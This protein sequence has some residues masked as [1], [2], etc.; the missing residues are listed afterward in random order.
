MGRYAALVQR[1]GHRRWFAAVGRWTT[2]LDRWLHRRTKGRL[3]TAGWHPLPS[4]LLTTTGRKSG[5]PRTQ[6]LLYARDGGDYVVVGSNWGQAHH[7]AWSGNLLAQPDATVTV[8]GR[9]EPVRAV[10][11]EGDDR[12]HLLAEL[13]RVWPAYRTYQARASSRDLRVFRLRPRG[14]DG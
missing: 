8:D 13:A 3:T 11:V 10:F 6:P 4:L 5:R 14:T 9:T 2:P 7:P 12:E 1:L